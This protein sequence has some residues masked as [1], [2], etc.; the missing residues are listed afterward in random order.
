MTENQNIAIFKGVGDKLFKTY[1][2]EKSQ[3]HNFLPDLYNN[4]STYL[5]FL[6]LCA[7]SRVFLLRQIWSVNYYVKI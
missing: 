2:R 7:N 5:K 4:L 1:E 6:G 3:V